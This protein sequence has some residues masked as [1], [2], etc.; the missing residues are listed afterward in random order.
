[1]PS[2][3]VVLNCSN[4][5]DREKNKSNY[6]FSSIVKNNGKEGLKLSKLRR[7]KWL[8]EIFREDVTEKKLEKTRIKIMLSS[9]LSS[10]FTHKYQIW[11]ANTYSI[12]T[13]IELGLPVLESSTRISKFYNPT[14]SEPKFR[15]TRIEDCLC[16][17]FH[18]GS[19]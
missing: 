1:M 10:V 16:I 18:L 8:A 14:N 7:E 19:P 12:L 2:F 6:H 15:K 5:V 4:R 13:V 11:K 3:C 17:G 9:F